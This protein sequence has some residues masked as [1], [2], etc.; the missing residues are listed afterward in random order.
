MTDAKCR[1]LDQQLVELI[2]QG[3][4][5]R[6]ESPWASPIAIVTNKGGTYRLCGDFRALNAI[7]E[8][9]RYSLPCIDEIVARLGRAHFFTTFDLLR[10]YLQ[11]QMEECR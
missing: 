9:D 7:T 4:I 2:E 1:I 11:V 8:A 3:V 6:L 10:G 5:E